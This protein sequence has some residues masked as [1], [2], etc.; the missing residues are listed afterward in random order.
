MNQLVSE[1]GDLAGISQLALPAARGAPIPRGN[2]PSSA[3]S[4][5]VYSGRLERGISDDPSS[6]SHASSGY[7]PYNPH[8]DD[9]EQ[10]ILPSNF[11]A[12]QPA[13]IDTTPYYQPGQYQQTYSEP[14][15][16]APRMRQSSYG[17]GV[18]LRDPG[19][20]NQAPHDPVRRV[21]KHQRRSSSRNQLVSPVSSSS[22][23]SALPP[24]AVSWRFACNKIKADFE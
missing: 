22:H 5:Q 16:A 17:G 10:P 3:E 15:Q 20:T 1:K 21:A 9:I 2:S 6:F 12:S 19:V 4:G 11:P 7:S 13:P 24:G 8:D 23:T 14:E 18:Q